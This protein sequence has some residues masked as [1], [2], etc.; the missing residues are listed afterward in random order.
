MNQAQDGGELVPPSY[1]QLSAHR[2]VAQAASQPGPTVGGQRG[3]SGTSLKLAII[4]GNL[5][6]VQL[7][8]DNGADLDTAV[9]FAASRGKFD[10]A[11]IFLKRGANVGTVHELA[12]ARYMLRRWKDISRLR[13]F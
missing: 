12:R 5:S 7:M 3:N 9:L 2:M 11:E 4:N 8:L 1:E 13:E 6:T 10:I